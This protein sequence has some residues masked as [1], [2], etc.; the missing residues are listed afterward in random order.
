MEKLKNKYIYSNKQF[1]ELRGKS[2]SYIEV[3]DG[4]NWF[5]VYN[6]DKNT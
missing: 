4:I 1:K 5:K 3:D 6:R 2:S